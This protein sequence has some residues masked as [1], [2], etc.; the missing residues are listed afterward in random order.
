MSDGESVN[1]LSGPLH[2]PLK[3]ATKKKV[4]GTSKDAH[5]HLKAH[6]FFGKMTLL[7][8]EYLR[9]YLTNAG[10]SQ[11]QTRKDSDKKKKKSPQSKQEKKRKK[12]KRHKSLNITM[13]KEENNNKIW[14]L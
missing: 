6:T 1:Q 8:R 13:K 7:Q 4:G 5:R 11:S 2:S 3:G 9:K 10:F 14:F 12:K